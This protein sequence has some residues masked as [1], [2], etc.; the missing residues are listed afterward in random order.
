MR[1]DFIEF[2]GSEGGGQ[3]LCSVLSL[4]MISGQLLCICNICGWCSCLG[5]LWQYFIVVCV[6]VEICVVEVE[7]V[8]F[9]LC[10][11]VFWFGVI[12]VGDY[13]FVIGFV[14]SC[15]LVL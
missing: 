5:L 15:L 10:E 11:L 4:L 1:K 6:V 3:I 8:E 14:G 9:G 7:G 13:V 12:C 2:D